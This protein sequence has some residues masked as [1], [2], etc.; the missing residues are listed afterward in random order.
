MHILCTNGTPTVDTLDHLPSLPLVIDYQDATETM[1]TKDKR[2]VSQALQLRARVLR[3]VF[4]ISPA[5]LK[6][7]LPLMDDSFPILEHLCLSSTVRD[8]DAGLIFPETF[9]APNLRHLS[10]LGIGLPTG[11][12]LLS[13][14]LSL[15]SL[16]LADIQPSGYFIPKHLVARLR[17]LPQLEELSI[18]FA[19]PIPRPS[20]EEELLGTLE[21]T[22]ATLPVLKRLTFRGVSSY[23][24]CLL[25]QIS[26]PLLEHLNIALFNQAAFALPHLS[27]FTHAPEGLKRPIVSVIF[28]YDAVSVITS[29]RGQERPDGP[30]SSS[31]RVMCRQFEWQVD[32]AVQICNALRPVLSRV[33]G[34][35]LDFGGQ[36][37]PTDWQDG[38]V[39][40]G[41][42]R[43]LL[44]PFVAV[45]KLRVCHALAWELSSALQPDG[46]GLNP[47]LLPSLR[48]LAPQLEAEHAIN[49]FGEFVDARLIA[50]QP[51]HLTLSPV[52]RAQPVFYF[53]N[54]NPPKRIWRH[55]R[56]P[57]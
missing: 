19:T 56:S 30:P 57:V 38:A 39:D 24:E 41:T 8:E 10:L 40:V 26:A 52:P 25:A 5:V 16:T 49:A 27:R 35:T 1:R 9:T 34:L 22:P 7:L 55:V 28:E 53:S 23:L 44:R 32:C 20:A 43:A 51:V 18:I 33:E 42:W 12:P 54:T 45:R 48:E 47:M 2:G 36:R 21:P 37:T 46:A 13:S 6:M 3:V 11:L 50:G 31:F 4:T 15:V 14:T 29:E 17:S